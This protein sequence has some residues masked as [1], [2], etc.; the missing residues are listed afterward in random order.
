MV[1]MNKPYNK[2]VIRILPY[3]ICGITSLFYLYEYLIRVMPSAM[4][5]QLMLGFGISAGGLGILSSL[6][7]Y[8]Y[9]PMQIPAGMIYDRFGARTVL[10]VM[11]LL[12]AAGAFLFGISNVFGLALLARWICGAAGA[13]AFVGAVVVGTRWLPAHY[14]AVYTGLVQFLGAMGAI[15]GQGPISLLT[16]KVGWHRA[17]IYVS[18]IGIIIAAIVYSLVKDNPM[19]RKRISQKHLRTPIKESARLV[20]SSKQNWWNALYSMAIWTPIVVFGTL[21]G[22]P[23]ISKL[24][25]ISHAAAGAHISMIW[26]GVGCAGP[27]LGWWQGKVG[28]RKPAMVFAGTLGVIASILVIYFFKTASI[29]SWIAFFCYG[30]AASAQSLPFALCADLNP[31]KVIGTAIGFTNMAVIAGGVI[32]QPFVGFIMDALWS[33]QKLGGV[34]IYS[35]LTYQKTLMIL[36][37][38]FIIATLTAIFFIKETRCK[39]QFTQD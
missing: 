32:V 13:F 19:H 16:E 28:R 31:R 29:F 8:G 18:I 5:H 38:S 7:F 2:T 12:C 26:V 9:A 27:L 21:W 24:Y 6:F 25:H 33:G 3:V 22:I 10:A 39:Q 37:A 34:P 14:L 17:A 20:L 4:T 1:F 15:I 36:P 30:A 35:V 23:Y 11:I